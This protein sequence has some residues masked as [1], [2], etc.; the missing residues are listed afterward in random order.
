V[1]VV[2]Q[3]VVVKYAGEILL[4][5]CDMQQLLYRHGGVRALCLEVV[6]GRLPTT[7]LWLVRL[8]GRFEVGIEIK[9]D[10]GWCRC[11]RRE[12]RFDAMFDASEEIWDKCDK[13]GGGGVG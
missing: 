9:G 6:G 10:G 7:F 3:L 11:E 12:G 4:S 5:E 1:E 8:D 13:W 2:L